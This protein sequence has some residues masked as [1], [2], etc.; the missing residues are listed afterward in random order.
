MQI[1]FVC[2]TAT[3][4]KQ[5][6]GIQRRIHKPVQH[7]LSKLKRWRHTPSKLL[8]KHN[9]PNDTEGFFV[10]INY[11]KSR[12]LLFGTYQPPSQND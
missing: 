11:R 3:Y 6:E 5:E 10:E 8:A 1:L 7:L 12:W 2:L 4:E 9:F